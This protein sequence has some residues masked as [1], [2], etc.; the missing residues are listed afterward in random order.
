MKEKSRAFTAAISGRETVMEG[1]DMRAVVLTLDHGQCIPWHYHSTIT[2]AFVC[3]KGPMV[4]E[5][6]APRMTHVLK[7]GERCSVPPMTAH[8]VHGQNDGACEFLI[9]QGAGEYDNILVGGHPEG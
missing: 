2:D 9:L 1:A 4:V 8:Y 5:T 6:R 3:L 7:P